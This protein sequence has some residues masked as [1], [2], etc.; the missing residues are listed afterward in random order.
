[1]FEIHTEQGRC[2]P[3]EQSATTGDDSVVP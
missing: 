2:P 3:P 1:V